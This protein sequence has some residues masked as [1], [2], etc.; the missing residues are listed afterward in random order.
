MSLSRFS[1]IVAVDAG[2][3]IAKKGGLP[4][5]SESDMS[6]FRKTTIGN[7][8]NAVIMG[9][10]TYESIPEEH[11][12]LK[13]RHN[14]VISRTWRQEDNPTISV[15]P[16]LIEALAGL[17]SGMNQY[18]DVYVAGGEQI[19]EETV[20][21]YLY[22]CDRIY[23]TKFKT[24]YECDQFFP[25]S[26]VENLPQGRDPQK[27]RECTRYEFAPSDLH[28]P[29]E[30][31]MEWLRTIMET[32][33]AKPDRTGVGTRSLFGEVNMKFNLQNRFPVITTKKVFYD[34]CIKE[35]L[36][37]ISGKT[38]THI[39]EDQGVNYWK[40]N[41]TREFLDE[42]GLNWEEGDMGPGYGFLWRHFGAKYD[43]CDKDYSG[44]GTDQ[45]RN[46]IEGIRT[47]PH[48][49]RHILS[50]W[51]P[52][53]LSEMA[54]PPCH[55]F[56][57]FNVSGDR[58]YLDCTLYQRSGDMFLGVPFNIIM[59]SMLTCMIAHITQ[60]KP[61]WFNH[62]IGDAHIYNNHAD[63]VR[64][65]LKRTPRPFPTLSFRNSARIHEIDD[66]SFEN[67]VVNGYTSWQHIKA[68]MAV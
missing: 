52:V 36:F 60:L 25:W 54:L 58:Q 26:R 67:F 65:Q 62:S 66:F 7:G 31:Y 9:R 12:P 46:L 42:R 16:S 33:E 68:D 51:N 14:I 40:G 32:G 44:Q 11:R 29:E 8:K 27:Y 5:K 24:N 17:G 1:I 23:V 45:L 10:V 49:R 15:Y 37:F 56:V 53:Q 38:D 28:H 43:G 41:T 19:Y 47:N 21:E 20:Q 61:R 30:Q 55:C 59:Y 3:G 22:L 35:L 63:Q 13:N 34:S 39:L 57:Q 50:A 18:D 64:R 2:N 6:F 48:S 4:W